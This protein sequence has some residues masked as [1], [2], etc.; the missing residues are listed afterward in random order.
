LAAFE[1][2]VEDNELYVLLFDEFS[3]LTNLSLAYAVSLEGT[4]PSLDYL[5]YDFE[6]QSLD[7]RLELIQA[8]MV[9]LVFVNVCL[10]HAYYGAAL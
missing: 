6:S 7:K 5:G 3:D 10:E 4:K 8:H 9:Y 2:I 1:E